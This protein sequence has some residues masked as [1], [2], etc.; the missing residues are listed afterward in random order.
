M[1]WHFRANSLLPPY[2]PCF[3]SLGD[4]RESGSSLRSGLWCGSGRGGGA[5]R[6]CPSRSSLRASR[7]RTRSACRRAEYVAESATVTAEVDLREA[8]SSS[9][10]SRLSTRTTTASS[11][12]PSSRGS[13]TPSR[14]PWSSAASSCGA[15]APRALAPSIRPRSPSKTGST[16]ARTTSAPRPV[17]ALDVELPLLDVLPHGHRHIATACTSARVRTTTSFIVA[18]PPSPYAA[19]PPA[20]PSPPAF[21]ARAPCADSS[22]SSGSPAWS[23][24]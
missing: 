17:S 16:S 18:T 7:S 23:T 19:R 9:R 5:R 21:L 15:T 4:E 14:A 8:G 3:P 6:R 1:K 20:P 24:S 12:T 10:R 2:S 11:R 22:R 13:A